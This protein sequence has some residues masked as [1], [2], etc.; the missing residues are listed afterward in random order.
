MPS[1]QSVK[2]SVK[3]G[4]GMLLVFSVL[5]F[6]VT[7]GVSIINTY[8]TT[9]IMVLLSIV[10]SA[11]VLVWLITGIVGLL[12]SR[13]DANYKTEVAYARWYLFMMFLVVVLACIQSMLQTGLGIYNNMTGQAEDIKN[14]SPG[15]WV[16][17]VSFY[18][19]VIGT[20]C[21]TMCCCSLCFI[22]AAMNLQ[23]TSN[24]HK[25][26]RNS[27]IGDDTDSDEEVDYIKYEQNDLMGDEE[28]DILDEE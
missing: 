13:K 21:L 5:T 4:A 24:L 25:N 6:P 2:L 16:E 12:A 17:V 1:Y 11:T 19:S 22:S 10:Q 15:F 9:W 8:K 14:S 3:I 7:I 28:N 20:V 18:I 26:E 23:V 27:L